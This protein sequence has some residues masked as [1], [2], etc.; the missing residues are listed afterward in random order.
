MLRKINL[1]FVFAF[2]P[3][4]LFSCVKKIPEKIEWQTSLDQGL[5]L[6]EK[7]NRKLLVDFFRED[8]KWCERLDDSTFTDREV[9]SLTLD[10]VFVKINGKE[11]TLLT[12][13][14]KVSAYPTVLILKPDGEEIERI[15]GYLPPREFFRTVKL[16]LKGKGTLTDLEEM[17]NKDSADVKLLLR[18][19]EKYMDRK[20]Y[21]EAKD[22]FRKVT[23]IDSKNYWGKTD[24]A[25]FN[26]A[27]SHY[28]ENEYK[29]AIEKFLKLATEFPK[30]SLGVEADEYI[31]YVYEKMGDTT[32]ALN[33][34]EKFLGKHPTVD[35]SEREWVEG[36]IKELK[37]EK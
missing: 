37:G 24:S 18:V 23:N 5:E 30:S 28:R 31:P 32:K 22:L 3:L 34:Y 29:D 6:A 19:G 17:L 27:Y 25:L 13:E 1:F 10:F 35:K 16:Y 11:D 2:F 36:R 14:H 12:N 20:R 33:L 15:V 4:V 9:I 8:C 7:Q 21:D 26:L